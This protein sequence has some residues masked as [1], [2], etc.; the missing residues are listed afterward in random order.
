[1]AE[2]SF[3]CQKLLDENKHGDIPGDKILIPRTLN[4]IFVGM[5]GECH[6]KKCHNCGEIKVRSITSSA[7]ITIEPT[8]R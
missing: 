7:K 3:A 5:V 1:M 4:L 8:N 2:Y 6:V